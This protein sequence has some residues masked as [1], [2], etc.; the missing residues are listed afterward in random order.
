M[1]PGR[2]RRLASDVAT[3]ATL[4]T[5]GERL[6]EVGPG[7]GLLLQE[8]L[9]AHPGLVATAVDRSPLAVRRTRGRNAAA[10]AAGRL[11]V[12]EAALADLTAAVGPD[13]R[14]D[15]VVL[16]D[17]NVLWTGPATAEVA[18]LVRHLAP[19]AVVVAVQHPPDPARRA[20]IAAR[21]AASLTGAGLSVRARGPDEDPDAGAVVVARRPTT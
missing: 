2:D 19:G 8:L 13:A 12:H 1:A 9:A 16:V 17:V 11:T 14:F 15:V 5:G 21:V 6:L 10:V 3:V 20:D 4:L 18:T 7:A